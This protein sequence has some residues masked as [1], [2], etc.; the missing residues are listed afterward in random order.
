MATHR[1]V[2]ELMQVLHGLQKSSTWIV[3]KSFHY[4]VILISDYATTRLH[5]YVA[6]IVVVQF[7]PWFNFFLL[8]HI[9]YQILKKKQLR[10]YVAKRLRG[11]AVTGLRG[12][13][14]TRLRGYAATR[15]RGYA[16]T[17][18]RGYAATRLR[19]YAATRLHGY[20]AT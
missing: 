5:V 13:A 8:F 11:Y 6:I 1:S 18:L 3:T 2:Y 15:L 20:A 17:R 16:A 4:L 14:A 12:Y 10:D 7:Y 9:H 19:G